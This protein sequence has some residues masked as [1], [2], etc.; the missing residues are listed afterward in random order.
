MRCRSSG[1]SVAI[2]IAAAPPNSASTSSRSSQL[3]PNADDRISGTLPPTSHTDLN[4]NWA[5]AMST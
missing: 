4:A 2:A 5:V 1:R 3:R